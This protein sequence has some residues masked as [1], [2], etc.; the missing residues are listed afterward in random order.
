MTQPRDPKGRFIKAAPAAATEQ[1]VDTMPSDV[2]RDAWARWQAC[3][4]GQFVELPPSVM[5]A[6]QAQRQVLRLGDDACLAASLRDVA[7]HQH[8]R[9]VHAPEHRVTPDQD[10]LAWALVVALGLKWRILP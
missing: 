9:G 8:G 10:R 3:K 5:E 7:A 1:Y 4:P 6:I 2:D